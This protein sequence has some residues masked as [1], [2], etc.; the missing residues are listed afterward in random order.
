MNEETLKMLGQ[1]NE[2]T[3]SVE[4]LKISVQRVSGDDQEIRENLAHIWAVT[5]NLERR[6]A[7]PEVIAGFRTDAVHQLKRVH[8]LV[9][10]CGSEIDDRQFISICFSCEL[11]LEKGRKYL[12][13]ARKAA[14]RAVDEAKIE[15]EA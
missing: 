1:L 2:I 11:A 15:M 13:M 4:V 3:E 6:I 7:R 9:E 5:Q 12:N 14:N 8:Q 10:E